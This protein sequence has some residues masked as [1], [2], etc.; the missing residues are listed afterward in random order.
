MTFCAICVDDL[1]PFVVRPLGKGNADVSVCAGC[2]SDHPRSGKVGTFGE[3]TRTA[4]VGL[5]GSGTRH[6]RAKGGL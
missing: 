1:G 3:S 4:F 6:V 5:V 2:D